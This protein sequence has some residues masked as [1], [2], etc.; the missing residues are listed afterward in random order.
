MLA[1]RLECSDQVPKRA[2]VGNA[3]DVTDATLAEWQAQTIIVLRIGVP[4][5]PVVGSDVANPGVGAQRP[6]LNPNGDWST[7]EKSPKQWFD[8]SRY[9]WHR[10]TPTGR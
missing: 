5:T 9:V 6:N 2:F 7:F 1:L 10:S 4:Y 8:P 3:K